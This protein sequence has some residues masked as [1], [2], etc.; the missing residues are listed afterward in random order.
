M[1]L[2]VFAKS[3]QVEKLQFKKKAGKPLAITASLVV[4]SNLLAMSTLT[5]QNAETLDNLLKKIFLW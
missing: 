4:N 5:M 2:A 1:D 3:W